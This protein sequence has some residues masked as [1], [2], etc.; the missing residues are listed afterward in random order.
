ML[1][2]GTRRTFAIDPNDILIALTDQGNTRI[3]DY[4]TLVV[5][6]KHIVLLRVPPRKQNQSVKK[7]AHPPRW[8]NLLILATFTLMFVIC[9]S[10][11][12]NDC[13]P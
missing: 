6:L 4:F 5:L 9:M 3:K 10:V 11:Y 7:H 2:T 13:A 12:I 8:F 1:Y